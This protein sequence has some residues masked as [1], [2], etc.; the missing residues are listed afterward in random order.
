MSAAETSDAEKQKDA[1]RQQWTAN[2]VG[3]RTR[4]AEHA[5][6]S[7]GA[8]ELIVE[9]AQV[10]PSMRVLDVA[11]GSGEPCLM[12]AERVGP[13]GEVTATDLVPDMLAAAEEQARERGL[14]N[15]RFQH[16]DAQTLPFPHPPF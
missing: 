2:A 13:N 5:I 9:A 8:T 12:L 7:R 11:S 6:T 15:I 1:M 16:A 14:A 3:W 4:Q 10:R